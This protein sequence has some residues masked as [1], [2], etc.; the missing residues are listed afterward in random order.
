MAITLVRARG[1][2]AQFY[3]NN[4]HAATVSTSCG[5]W[6]VA[7]ATSDIILRLPVYARIKATLVHAAA[8]ASTRVPGRAGCRERSASVNDDEF[9]A[10]PGGRRSYSSSPLVASS[11]S[12]LPRADAVPP[13]RLTPA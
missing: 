5:R 10:K 12:P 1:T 9:Q 6:N 7:A 11:L 4:L 8:T 3:S 2:L 13:R